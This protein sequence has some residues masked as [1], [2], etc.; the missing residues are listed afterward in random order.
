M[1]MDT[2]I[3]LGKHMLNMNTMLNSQN[4]KCIHTEKYLKLLMF[5][6]KIK[7]FH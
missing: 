7:M 6:N 4:K 5:Y 1:L 3:E 2:F